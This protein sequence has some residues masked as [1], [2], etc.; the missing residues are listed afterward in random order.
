MTNMISDLR[1]K[2]MDWLFVHGWWDGYT[3]VSQDAFINHRWQY[4]IKP[5]CLE[6][7]ET[8]SLLWR[9]YWSLEF[10]VLHFGR[11][12]HAALFILAFGG[13][14]DDKRPMW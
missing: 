9:R 14:R 10:R 5:E 11:K 7:L 4:M 3:V 2:A 1:Q 12:E 6:F 13:T 8:S